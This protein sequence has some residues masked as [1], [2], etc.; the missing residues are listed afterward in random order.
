MKSRLGPTL[1]WLVSLLCAASAA[2]PDLPSVIAVC[3]GKFGLCRYVDRQTRQEILPAR[4]E[5]ASAFSEGLAAVRIDGRFGYIDSRGEIVITPRF[6][7][8]G[9]FTHGLAEVLVGPQVGIINRAGEIVVPPIFGRAYPLTSEVILAVEGVWSGASVENPPYQQIGTLPGLYDDD[10]FFKN[11][12]LYHIS[13]HWIRQPSLQVVRLFS[14]D[15][16]GLIWASEQKSFDGPFGLLA[17]D[18]RWIIEPQY[19]RV[20]SL[21]DERAVVGKWAGH[22]IEMLSGAVDPA[23]RLV[24]PLRPWA[25]SGWRN[26]WATASERVNGRQAI[27]DRDGN[28]VG[29]RIFDRV[30]LPEQGDVAAVMIGDRWMGL[31]RAGKIV[32]NPRNV[33]ASCPGGIRLIEIDGRIQITDANGQ[34]TA[35]YLF[36]PLRWLPA[37]DGPFVV[38][39]NGKWSPVGL[40]GHLLVDPPAFDELHPFYAG[41]AAAKQG[42]KWGFI[43]TS[44]RFV[45]E[46]KFD[47]LRA[48]GAGVYRAVVDG[49]EV[50]LRSSGE[51]RTDPR[52]KPVPPPGPLNCGHGVTVIDRNGQWGIADADGREIVAPRYRA[53]TCFSSGVAWVPIDSRRQWCALGPDG[54]VR[55]RPACR[56]TYYPYSL[57]EEYPEKLDDDPFE[58]NVLWLRADLEF[59]AG[60]RETPPRL[61]YGGSHP[62]FSLAPQK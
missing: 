40:D 53:V 29:G 52:V 6:D 14:N 36:E 51:E 30:Q 1:L 12:G 58:S 21:K 22:S 54:A 3:D 7:R 24:I 48:R 45:V 44:G 56:T 8:A 50:W 26:G 35:P 37:C 59:A 55:E 19:A 23:G 46:P 27:F 2:E 33:V 31:D 5:Q 62:K 15:G 61:I 57:A 34:P 49:R 41:Y 39:L 60:R 47:N 18:G 32:P 16:R 42:G 4:Y 25:L 9:D 10:M 38:E 28:V 17:S 43:D 20:R 11:I 13:G